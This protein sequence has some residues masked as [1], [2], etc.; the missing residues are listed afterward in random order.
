MEGSEAGWPPRRFRG[1]LNVGDLWRQPW[2]LIERFTRAAT[3]YI[4]YVL[5][6]ILF[7]AL[8][9]YMYIR[10]F[11][12]E[13]GEVS[14][15]FL[16]DLWAK[17]K[18]VFLWLAGWL[19][20]PP[21]WLDE[22]W[23]A[24]ISS[25]NS[26]LETFTDWWSPT[27]GSWLATFAGWWTSVAAAV[28]SLFAAFA[29]WRA[30]VS[31]AD[32]WGWTWD[33][34]H[35]FDASKWGPLIRFFGYF[36][37]FIVI[38]KICITDPTTWSPLV[39]IISHQIFSGPTQRM[40]EYIVQHITDSPQTLHVMNAFGKFRTRL[41]SSFNISAVYSWLLGWSSGIG[42][43]TYL[44]IIPEPEIE[45]GSHLVCDILGSNTRVSI[46]PEPEI[47]PG[48]HLLCDILGSDRREWLSIGED[49]KQSELT[50]EAEHFPTVVEPVVPLITTIGAIFLKPMAPIVAFLS[51]LPSTIKR[52]LDGMPE[53]TTLVVTTIKPRYPKQITPIVA[54]LSG[55]L[56]TIKRSSDSILDYTLKYIKPIF[57]PIIPI[58]PTMNI[59]FLK[60]IKKIIAFLSGS[61]FTIKQPLDSI[62]DYTLRHTTQLAS[63]FLQMVP[64]TAM[65]FYTPIAPIVKPILLVLTKIVMVFKKPIAPTVAFFASV[66]SDPRF[67]E[68]S[69]ASTKVFIFASLIFFALFAGG[70]YWFLCHYL[71]DWSKVLDNAQLPPKETPPPV[72]SPPLAATGQ[73]LPGASRGS[74]EWSKST[75]PDSTPP[76]RNR[77]SKIL[78]Y[79]HRP[80]A[81]LRLPFSYLGH[82]LAYASVYL[83]RPLA[84]IRALPSEFGTAQY[85][86]PLTRLLATGKIVTYIDRPF[87][88]IRWLLTEFKDY[89]FPGPPMRRPPLLSQI[90]NYSF[91]LYTIASRLLADTN[92][93]LASL[94][95]IIDD[96]RITPLQAISDAIAVQYALIT[97]VQ[98]L[99][100]LVRDTVLL[101]IIFLVLTLMGWDRDLFSKQNPFLFRGAF[102]AIRSHFW[103]DSLT[104]SRRRR[105]DRDHADVLKRHHFPGFA[106]GRHRYLPQP[107][108][109]PLF[110]VA[111]GMVIGCFI[112]Y[113]APH[114][115]SAQNYACD[116]YFY[117]KP[118]FIS[119]FERWNVEKVLITVFSGTMIYMTKG[120]DALMGLWG[121]LVG[122]TTR[123]SLYP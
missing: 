106:Q 113:S 14:W 2:A 55:S 94:R 109:Y 56:S 117:H 76:P 22:A 103:A 11:L 26:R 120:W 97:R 4:P 32:W 69:F 23:N 38:S 34:I 21:M 64:K 74:S 31:P 123:L 68:I 89:R 87:G 65:E 33:L 46:I 9:W 58:L 60:P 18:D 66:R 12:N 39:A 92:E 35:I 19:G 57:K 52:S 110:H 54:F 90:V 47:E 49:V 37:A 70:T 42:G 99:I 6:S 85:L 91:H 105:R 41:E 73:A 72:G 86:R 25:A 50:K 53:Y 36:A 44:A 1:L 29:G 63:T 20:L 80:L 28:G 51:G 27:V 67:L 81:Y 8:L 84:Y 96:Y 102:R 101:L 78:A 77:I 13:E 116:K 40:L 82:L 95:A 119:L 59:A 15:E 71:F 16:S 24:V 98:N 30:W 108:W 112:Y 10:I 17:I 93:K 114:H 121:A 100:L 79:I 122:G 88:Y 48:Y 118:F 111:I 61:L 43:S 7:Q 107:Q 3:Y 62:Q 75:G 83:L 104:S 115:P 45:P 5:S